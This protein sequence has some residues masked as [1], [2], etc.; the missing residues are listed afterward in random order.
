M[1]LRDLLVLG[2]ESSAFDTDDQV[3]FIKRQQETCELD[4]AKEIK[5]LKGVFSQRKDNIDEIVLQ[6]T[7]A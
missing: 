2:D 6:V 5:L 1:T 4:I 3:N 7:T